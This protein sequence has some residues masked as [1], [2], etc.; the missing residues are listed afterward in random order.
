MSTPDP[1]D[2]VSTEIGVQHVPDA[3]EEAPDGR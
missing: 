3:I 2:F 1:A